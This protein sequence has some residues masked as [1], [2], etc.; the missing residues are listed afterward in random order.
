[1]G[2]EITNPGAKSAENIE[3]ELT[4]Q[5]LYFTP[6]DVPPVENTSHWH[7]FSSVFYVVSGSA[8]LTD[9]ESGIVHEIGPGSR[10]SVPA[11]ALHAEKSQEGY[12]ILLGTT[13]D[14]ATFEGDVN[15]PPSDL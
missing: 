11:K 13:R 2:L 10:V 1:M 4:D 14:P 5:G 8:Q 7:D 3:A 15:L 6:L 9:I 12:S